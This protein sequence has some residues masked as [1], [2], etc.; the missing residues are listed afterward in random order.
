VLD[1]ACGTGLVTFRAAEAVAPAGEVVA[2]DISQAMVDI[3]RKTAED[4]GVTNVTFER[5]DAEDLRGLG[6]ASF[7]AALCGLGLMFM[8]EPGDALREML[9]VLKP[10][11]RAVSAVWGQRDRCGWA[12]IFPI[13]DARVQSEVCPMFFQL[14]TKQVLQLTLEQAGFAGIVHE[15]LA[16]V[17]HY[18]SAEEALGAAFLGGPVAL[19]Y[20]RF[21]EATRAAVHAEYLASIDAYRAGGGYE[22]PGEFVIALGWKR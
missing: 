15:R 10:G 8:P 13:T 17:L 7:D 9:R 22:V 1:V 18:D 21:D 6:D 19:A 14:G 11:G 3:S 4:R 16:T 2:T 20:D 12:E 5:M